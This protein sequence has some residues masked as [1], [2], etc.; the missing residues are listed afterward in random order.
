M[1]NSYNQLV[2]LTMIHDYL[3]IKDAEN[4]QHLCKKVFCL[5]VLVVNKAAFIKHTVK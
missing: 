1:L 5:I 3:Y 4:Y 2:P